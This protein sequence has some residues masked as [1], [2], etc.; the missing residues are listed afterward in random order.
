MFD[1]YRL[2]TEMVKATEGLQ[3]LR[4][5]A[6]AEWDAEREALRAEVAAAEG[7]AGELAKEAANERI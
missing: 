4:V 2:S 6:A 7:R 5:A 3:E 1:G